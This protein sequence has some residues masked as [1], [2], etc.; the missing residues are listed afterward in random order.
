MLA[1]FL[2]DADT[3]I[4]ALGDEAIETVVAALAGD[5]NVIEAAAA[6]FESFR[7][8]MQAVENFHTFSLERETRRAPIVDSAPGWMRIRCWIA[9][10][11]AKR[12]RLSMDAARRKPVP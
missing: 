5:E 2:K 1:R 9:D 3:C 8:W 4:A 11:T 10:G 7:D 12:L 6:G